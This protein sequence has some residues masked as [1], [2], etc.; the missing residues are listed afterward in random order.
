MALEIE[1]RKVEREYKLKTWFQK[2]KRK[3]RKK[4]SLH[5]QAAQPR[6]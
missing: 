2:E 6:K 1:G 4:S 3:K 5:H